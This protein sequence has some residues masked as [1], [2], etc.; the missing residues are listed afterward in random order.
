ML[1]HFNQVTSILYRFPSKE[2]T[3]NHVRFQFA[4]KRVQSIRWKVFSIINYVFLFKKTTFPQF[5]F[6]A[7]R[8]TAETNLKKKN[9]KK[10]N[11]KKRKKENESNDFFV[12]L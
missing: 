9:P 10:N 7:R 3:L 6:F 11:P 1:G 12:L 8:R 4:S 5:F 2:N